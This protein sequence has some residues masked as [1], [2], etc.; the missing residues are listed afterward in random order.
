MSENNESFEIIPHMTHRHTGIV[1]GCCY[2]IYFHSIPSISFLLNYSGG[3][4]GGSDNSG[5]DANLPAC[6]TTALP[7]CNWHNC[8]VRVRKTKAIRMWRDEAVS[9][10]RTGDLEAAPW[11]MYV[12]N[13]GGGRGLQWGKRGGAGI[14]GGGGRLAD[15]NGCFL[16]L[17]CIWKAYA[18]SVTD[19]IRLFIVGFTKVRRSGGER[20]EEREE[21]ERRMHVINVQVDMHM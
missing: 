18:V 1:S 7:G 8:Q 2:P 21:G 9:L 5:C 6:L 13:G 10:S 12:S 11:M 20:R 16:S 14:V 17:L 19:S 15:K 4:S 3:R